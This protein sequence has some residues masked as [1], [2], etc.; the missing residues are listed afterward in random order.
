[1]KQH[2]SG[3]IIGLVVSIIVGFGILAGVWLS[4]NSISSLGSESGL[5]QATRTG[6]DSATLELATYPD[7]HVC[8]ADARGTASRLGDLLLRHK[9][10][11]Q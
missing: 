9:R 4:L 6:P 1:M 10:S 8:H 11:S 5:V 7:G 2:S 3:I